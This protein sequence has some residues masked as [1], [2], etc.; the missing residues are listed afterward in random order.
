[1]HRLMLHVG[2]GMSLIAA[3]ACRA[4]PTLPLAIV[5]ARN[6][7]DRVRELLRQ[8]HDPGAGTD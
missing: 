3:S 2:V 6:A 5:A 7:A 8:H 4:E 1:M